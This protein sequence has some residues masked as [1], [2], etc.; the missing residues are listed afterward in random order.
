MV[1]SVLGYNIIIK[2]HSQMEL[3]NLINYLRAAA[4][5]FWITF[6]FI[7]LKWIFYT[8]IQNLGMSHMKLVM[9]FMIDMLMTKPTIFY[10]ELKSW[11]CHQSPVTTVIRMLFQTWRCRFNESP[12]R[13]SIFNHLQL[14]IQETIEYTLHMCRIN[15]HSDLLDQYATTNH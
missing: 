9:W 8:A 7:K 12:R 4:N 3:K 6:C 10:F 14:S 5:H 1:A 11:N 13:C 2:S 15:L